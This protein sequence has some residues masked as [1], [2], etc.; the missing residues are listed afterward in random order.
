MCSTHGLGHIIMS[1]YN[2]ICLA[3]EDI[4][5][6]FQCNSHLYVINQVFSGDP[7]RI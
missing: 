7:D 3:A 4:A 1:D 2:R 6:L 5:P